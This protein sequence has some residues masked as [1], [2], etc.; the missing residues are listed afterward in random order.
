MLFTIRCLDCGRAAPFMPRS[1]QC[2]NCG[3]QWREA[4]YDL[5]A[6]AQ[7][8][9]AELQNRPFNL[10]RYRELL[11]IYE[12]NPTL[13]LGEGGTPLIKAANLGN[14][15]GLPNL[16]IKDERQGPTSS[17]K[18]RQAAVT[19]AALKEGGVT[20]MVAASTG[21]VAIALSAYAARAGIKLWA[22]VTSLVP[23]VKMREIALY[24]SQVVKITG[25]YD[26]AKQVAAE[27]A[28]QRGL[29]QDMGARTVT[30]VEAMKTIAF[31]I[32]EQ[33][34]I[35]EGA[36]PRSAANAPKWRTPDWYIQAVS[37]GM[38][39]VGVYKGFRELKQLGITERIPA[40]APIQAE[41]CA[42][43]VDGWK[44]GME[45][46]EPVLSPNTRIETLATGDPGRT[47]TLLRKQV[48]ETN[49]VFES[50]SDDDAFRAM[51]V[52]AKLEGISAE[53]AAAAAFAGLFKLVRTGAIK[54][55]DTVVVNCT[56]HTL[57]AEQ[58]LFDEN[59]TR[60]VDYP[61][62]MAQ[63]NTPEEGLL[64]AL[65]N[66]T[67]NRFS[68][69]AIVDDSPDARRLIR[70]ILQSQGDF[71]ITE[72]SNGN[73][74][75]ELVSREHPD[76]VI[77]DL[78]MPEVDGFAVLDAL[79]SK[80]ETTNIP[81]IVATA[82]ELTVSEKSRLQGQIQALMQKGDFLNDDFLDEVRSLIQ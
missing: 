49:G 16:Y 54:S 79:R 34:T 73:E 4:E 8:F 43:M 13:Y 56:G 51:H 65:N 77:L 19:I 31:E 37:G 58:F 66:V 20:E 62:V 10:W 61:S 14:M 24:G 41:G 29:Y 36:P 57:P 39:P 18:D 64:A 48:I 55:T 40:L 47:Y 35:M 59:W 76:I 11:P 53:P 46:A 9:P 63:S 5:Q 7:S 2:P 42:P 38:G 44:K 52:L 78:M 27:F 15:L 32:A 17:F 28:R 67:P 74:A 22:F 81:I 21:N 80:P 26:Q 82:K 23:G 75:I 6:V 68:R 72:A 71:E 50:V 1:M 25:S 60:D 30:A 45:K 12:P 69:I 70:R 3:S 33:L